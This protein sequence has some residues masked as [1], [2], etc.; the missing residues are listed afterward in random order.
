ME[1]YS[2]YTKS[3]G[4]VG[5]AKKSKKAFDPIERENQLIAAAYDLAE[6]QMK[7]GTAAAGVIVH[8]L[9]LATKREQLENEKLET[10][11]RLNEAKYNSIEFERQSQDL[12]E[13]ALN[14]I[15][16]YSPTKDE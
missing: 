11:N 5:L 6:Q 10:L 16:S 9:K 2:N 1:A 13:K 15:R 12:A 3:G 7:D 4:E 8:F 14:A